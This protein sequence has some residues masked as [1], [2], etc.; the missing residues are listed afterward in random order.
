[1]RATRSLF[2]LLVVT[3]CF[4]PFGHAQIT[5][6]TNDQAAPVPGVGHNYL[7][8][9][10]E[11]VNPG[12]GSVSLRIAAETP[13]GRG[14]T[15]PFLFAY[16]S[17]GPLR[18]TPGPNSTVAVLGNADTSFMSKNGWS[19]AFPL[20][21]STTITIP[22]VGHPGYCQVDT[23]FMFMDS[24]GTRN[25]FPNFSIAN[26]TE[27]NAV[28]VIPDTSYSALGSFYNL[29]TQNGAQD[30]QAV[31]F[32]VQDKS[33]TLYH[34]PYMAG[35]PGCV[36][37]CGIPD[38]I[39]D[40]NG[41]KITFSPQGLN[42]FP[43]TATDTTGRALLSIS[44]FDATG[45]DT[46]TVAGGVTPLLGKTP[47]LPRGTLSVA[48]TWPHRTNSAPHTTIPV[49]QL[50]GTSFPALPCQTGSLTNSSMTLRPAI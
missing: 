37:L 24:A 16:N 44:G 14:I 5:N 28:G 17:N 6:V 29:W 8:T 35:Y 34:Y 13:A 22:G 43:L 3:L 2:S 49:G 32:N 50:M 12:N 15:L 46:V 4:A 45:G 11:I 36:T 48:P 47:R 40:R 1:M 42:V 19:Y 7:G 18:L 23:G 21:S 10:E 31:P 38:F 9:L 39:E 27:C 26:Q 25:A 41:N 20:L 30:S 33:G